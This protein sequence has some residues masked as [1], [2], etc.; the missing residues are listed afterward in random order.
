MDGGHDDFD[1]DHAPGLPAPLPAGERL[2]WQGSPDWRALARRPFRCRTVALWFAL[3]LAWTALSGLWRGEPLGSLLPGLALTALGGAVAVGLLAGLA[4]LT[5]R[6]TIW[7]ITSE[8]LLIR[9]GIALPVTMNLPFRRI[10]SAALR[11]H[12]DARDPAATG[13]IALELVAD[14]RVSWAVMWPHVGPFSGGRTRPA[15][16]AVPSAPSV[17]KLLG[18]AVVRAGGHEA[19]PPP[20]PAAAH[21]PPA[22]TPARP[23][24]AMA[25]ASAA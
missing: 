6:A 10:A 8:R 15:L 12:G 14:E 3:V 22:G 25:R 13:D 24:P 16:R 4:V 11:V 20:A 23:A 18:E 19:S 21:A 7:S 1:F 5:A 2:L 9:F 17:A